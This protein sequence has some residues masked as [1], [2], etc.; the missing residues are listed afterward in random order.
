MDQ[1]QDWRAFVRVLGKHPS[2]LEALELDV[3]TRT[4]TCTFTGVLVDRHAIDCFEFQ[5]GDNQ[6]DVA[7]VLNGL[8]STMMMRD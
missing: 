4:I 8:V 6:G 5:L 7:R 1:H 2:C 3:E